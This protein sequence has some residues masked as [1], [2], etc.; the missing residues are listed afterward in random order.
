MGT[1]VTIHVVGHGGTERARSERAACIDRGV[2]WF[3]HIESVCSRFLPDS[4][5]RRLS[6]RIGTPTRVSPLLYEAIQFSLQVAEASDGAFDPTVGL[7]MED[8]GF[9]EEHRTGIRSRTTVGRQEPSTDNDPDEHPS[10]RRGGSPRPHFRDV[11]LDSHDRTITLRRPLVLDLGAVVKGL[12][13]DLAARELRPMENFAIDAGGDQLFSGSNADGKAWSVGIR[14]PRL[15][16]TVLHTLRLSNGAVCTSGDYERPVRGA[17]SDAA[18]H[19]LLDARTGT[20]ARAAASVT[21]IAPCAMAADALATAAF[22][23]GPVDGLRFLDRQGVDGL[24][25][26]P[27]FEEVMTA[28]M[29]DRVM[30]GAGTG[31]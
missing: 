29:R 8:R 27:S 20:T 17:E 13:V 5:L 12:A 9:T 4:E 30:T 14:R 2:A 28:G 26:T 19:H 1:V 11:I 6:S 24:I 10:S 3:R 23:L 16:H 15:P 21:V 25:V 7:L 18:D 31:A 22:A